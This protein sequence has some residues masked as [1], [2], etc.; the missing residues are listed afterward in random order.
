MPLYNIIVILIYIY[1][2]F[3]K[4]HK[5]ERCLLFYIYVLY[6]Y[7]ILPWQRTAPTESLP[8]I[9]GSKVSAKIFRFVRHP[10]RSSVAQRACLSVSEP[11]T[12]RVVPHAHGPQ[13]DWCARQSGPIIQM[14]RHTWYYYNTKSVLESQISLHITTQQD[15]GSTMKRSWQ[16]H[17]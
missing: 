3:F 15:H 7:F 4:N 9:K 17:K 16:I 8:N 12:R 13:P 1:I 11:Y 14:Y 5:L 10:R 6:Q 2:P